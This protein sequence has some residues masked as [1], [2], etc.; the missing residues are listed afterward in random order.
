MKITQIIII[1]TFALFAV[2][3][4]GGKKTSSKTVPISEHIGTAW[5]LKHLLGKEFTEGSDNNYWIQFNKEQRVN[6]RGDC[7]VLMGTF[8]SDENGTMAMDRLAGTM[9]LC[10]NQDLENRF[11]EVLRTVDHYK[12]ENGR[13]FLIRDNKTVAEFEPFEL[14]INEGD[15]ER[16][17]E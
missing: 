13:L 17:H 14:V 6:G 15:A 7:N 3:C 10:P 16:L 11:V 4:G 8:A 12:I 9:M 5:K 1:A 2:S